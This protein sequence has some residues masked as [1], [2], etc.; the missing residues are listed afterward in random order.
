MR[1]LAVLALILWSAFGLR[2][3]GARLLTRDARAF[4][5]AGP[6]RELPVDI[7]G[8][9]WRSED[10]PLSPEVERIAGVKDYVQ[11]A[12]R[13][14][15]REFTFYVGLVDAAS[16]NGIHHP[17]K[18]L[19]AHGIELEADP[20]VVL[21]VEG[22]GAPARFAAYRCRRSDGWSGYALSTFTY[23][24]RQ[25]HPGVWTLRWQ[26]IG[27]PGREYAVV[28]LIGDTVGSAELTRNHYAE[29]ARQA[30]AVLSEYLEP[31]ASVEA[32]RSTTDGTDRGEEDA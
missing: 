9:D 11:R 17:G 23:P 26:G 25:Y 31:R 10:R 4:S 19:R 5:P 12:C 14:G 16:D 20:E 7:F 32:D 28:S 15:R 2:L 21:D 8:P 1:R 30:C 3:L 24:V 13:R 29:L 27:L 22:L 18:C 6:L